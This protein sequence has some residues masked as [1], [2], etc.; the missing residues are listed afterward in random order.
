MVV[1]DCFILN[2]KG[3]WGGLIKCTKRTM[4]SPY[5]MISLPTDV[6]DPIFHVFYVKDCII[7]IYDSNALMIS[8][9]FIAT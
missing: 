7:I 5:L 4:V 3:D 9:L 1:T 8:L 2:C 6:T